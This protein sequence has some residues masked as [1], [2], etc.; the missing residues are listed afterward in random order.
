MLLR[1]NR[2]SLTIV[3]RT[4]KQCSHA[5]KLPRRELHGYA[6]HDNYIIKLPSWGGF[7]DR[8]LFIREFDTVAGAKFFAA[9]CANGAVYLHRAPLDGFFRFSSGRGHACELEELVKPYILCVYFNCGIIH[10]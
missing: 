8:N 3:M 10:F 7:S 5:A 6:V 9:L 4:G 2:R 1:H